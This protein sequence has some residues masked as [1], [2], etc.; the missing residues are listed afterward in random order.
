[1]SISIVIQGP[2]NCTS[3]GMIETYS[4]Y[5]KVIVSHWDN[6]DLSMLECVDAPYERVA[7]NHD[8]GIYWNASNIYRQVLTTHAGM[9]LVGTDFVIKVRSDEAYSD[10]SEVISRLRENP[11]RYVTNNIFFRSSGVGPFHP[12]DHLI[13]GPTPQMKGAFE[14]LNGYI[15]FSNGQVADKRNDRRDASPEVQIGVALILQMVPHFRWHDSQALMKEYFT[16]VPLAKLGKVTWRFADGDMTGNENTGI[17]GI[18]DIS[19]V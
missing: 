17:D 1:M 14:Y 10:L 2:L 11:K 16:I 13:A 18:T 6:D 12:S 15:P 3:L 5:G 4:K 7:S 9:K 19:E 8:I